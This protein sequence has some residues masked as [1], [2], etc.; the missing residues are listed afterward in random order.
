MSTQKS[1]MFFDVRSGQIRSNAWKPEECPR[2]K[3]SAT[4]RGTRL[5]G[6]MLTKPARKSET[7]D[8]RHLTNSLF[9]GRRAMPIA[10]QKPPI[11]YQLAELR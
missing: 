7:L 11:S 3:L 2:Q 8:I 6:L 5:V 9:L 1:R 4:L 10:D